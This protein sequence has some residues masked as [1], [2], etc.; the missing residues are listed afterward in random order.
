MPAD[1]R[2]SPVTAVGSASACR[3]GARRPYQPEERRQHSP[4]LLDIMKANPVIRALALLAGTS[5]PL[6]GA[7]HLPTFL[8][9]RT[10]RGRA[11]HGGGF[12]SRVRAGGSATGT[13][14]AVPRGRGAAVW[15]S[16]TGMPA[17]A[18]AAV[19]P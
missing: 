6:A 11:C 7:A 18:S 17:T 10:W 15:S 16:A 12:L 4:H 2:G 14:S 8:R 9:Q 13:K 3:R 1:G 19:A 5:A